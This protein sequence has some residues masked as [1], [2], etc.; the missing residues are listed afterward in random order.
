SLPRA[1]SVLFFF[2]SSRR[3][4]TRWPRD[5]SS[6]VC[7]SDLPFDCISPKAAI[8][9]RRKRAATTHPLIALLRATLGRPRSL[10][11]LA[12]QNARLVRI[13]HEVLLECDASWRRR[14]AMARRRL[15]I[16]LSACP[17]KCQAPNAELSVLGDRR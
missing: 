6:D 1:R 13:L 5:W 3:R 2:F 9:R 12:K 4:H 8:P 7:S 16:A 15:R 17:S 11:A 14:S 10:K